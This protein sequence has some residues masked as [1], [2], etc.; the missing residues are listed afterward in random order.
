VEEFAMFTIQPK[1]SSVDKDKSISD[2]SRDQS[3]KQKPSKMKQKSEE[4]IEEVDLEGRIVENNLKT[5]FLTFLLSKD[6]NLL[7]QTSGSLIELIMHSKV[8]HAI[9]YHS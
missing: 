1:K 8:S 4:E 5:Q 7:L 2:L 3:S 6:D 9:L